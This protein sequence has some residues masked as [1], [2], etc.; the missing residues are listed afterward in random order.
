M[1]DEEDQ[2]RAF[3]EDL[4]RVLEKYAH[5]ADGE[6]PSSPETD[7]FAEDIRGLMERNRAHLERRGIDV[8]KAVEE[9]TSLLTQTRETKAKLARLRRELNASQA[10]PYGDV[11][12]HG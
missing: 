6:P 7:A 2:E 10:G 11:R 1:T 5:S 12:Y 9:M 3:E 4:R 8:G